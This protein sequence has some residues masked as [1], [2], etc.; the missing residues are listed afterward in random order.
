MHFKLYNAW[1][2]LDSEYIVAIFRLPPSTHALIN[3]VSIYCT[4]SFPP[5]LEASP[6]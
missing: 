4:L 5:E 2:I 3:L 6:E 1:P